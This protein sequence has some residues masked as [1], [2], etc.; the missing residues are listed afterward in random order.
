MKP[1]DF[2]IDFLLDRIAIAILGVTLGLAFAGWFSF[3]RT[4]EQRDASHAET[5]QLE[6]D[7]KSTRF[8]LNE[9]RAN[10]AGGW[11]ITF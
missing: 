11:P 3:F 7:L 5:I 1:Q 10:V 9:L 4:V 6:E 8:E 2:L